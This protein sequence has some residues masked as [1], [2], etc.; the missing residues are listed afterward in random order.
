MDALELTKEKKM[1]L[2][3]SQLSGRVTQSRDPK[4]LSNM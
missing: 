4:Q 1:E 2:Y 3:I